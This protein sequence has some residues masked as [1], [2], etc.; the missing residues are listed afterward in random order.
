VTEV[1]HALFVMPSSLIGGAER[2]AFNLIVFLLSRGWRVSLVTMSRGRSPGWDQ[3]E[4]DPNFHWIAMTAKSEKSGVLPSVSA[5]VRL[6]RNHRLSLVYSSH[7]HINAM[8]SVLRRMGLLRT[9]ALVVRESTVIFMRKTPYPLLFFRMLY[10]LYGGI[11]ALICQ[12]ALMKS[13]LLEAVPPLHRLPV[14]VVPNPV[15]SDYIAQRVAEGDSEAGEGAI[16]FVFCGRLIPLKRPDLVLRALARLER[17]SWR[18]AHFLG[19]GDSGELRV[20]ASALGISERIVFRGNIDN[21]YAVF[22]RARVGVLASTVEG[23]PNVLLEMMAAGTGRIVSSLCTPAV[24]DLPGVDIVDPI[25]EER[26]AGALGTALAGPTRT[27]EYRAYIAEHRSVG[28]FW[29]RIRQMLTTRGCD[30]PS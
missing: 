12:T 6:S 18:S 9:R 3:L 4:C 13:H 2:V 29:N 27:D 24:L 15:N 25:D 11:D 28:S 26:L 16:D 10:R 22:A 20:L 21:P 23:F 17:G 14:V 30:V 1:K 8:L 5:M 19:R 7:A